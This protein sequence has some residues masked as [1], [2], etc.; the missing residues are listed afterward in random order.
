MHRPERWLNG[1]SHPRS[2]EVP[3][4]F[5]GVLTFFGGPRA[6]V[7]ILLMNIRGLN[8]LTLDFVSKQIGY[9]FALMEMKVLIS[10]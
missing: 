8:P 3:G 10:L 6:C 1:N 9:R 7:S 4:V 2:A 5:A